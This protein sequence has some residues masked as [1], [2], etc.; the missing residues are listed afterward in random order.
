M[1]IGTERLF[2]NPLLWNALKILVSEEIVSYFHSDCSPV[3]SRYQLEFAFGGLFPVLQ[4][5]ID[6]HYWPSMYPSSV[7][8]MQEIARYVFSFAERAALL[9]NKHAQINCL[10]TLLVKLKQCTN[11]PMKS[12]AISRLTQRLLVAESELGLSNE[13]IQ[14]DYLNRLRYLYL[15]HFFA[16]FNTDFKQQ[17]ALDTQLRR[18]VQN[19]RSA[20][21][22]PNSV[23]TQLS[24][25][26]CNTL[27]DD[28]HHYCEP[29][30]CDEV[31]RV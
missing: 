3:L 19:V 4:S 12:D 27:V 8:I 26:T 6:T 30:G 13:Q 28:H 20:Y 10:C 29:V 17:L 21:C 15:L 25:R 22:G 31:C 24:H 1:Q 2:E 7:M 11:A 23:K 18:Y 16:R 5:V 14:F 9:L